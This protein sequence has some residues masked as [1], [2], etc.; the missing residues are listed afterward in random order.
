MA[1]TSPGK[2][3]GRS[4]RAPGISDL[5][6]SR[7]KSIAIEQSIEVRQLTILAGANSSG[8]SSMMQ[9]LLLLKQTLEAPYDPGP[10]ELRGPNTAF[11]N[12]RQLLSRVEGNRANGFDVGVTVGGAPLRLRFKY[13]PKEGLVLQEMVEGA[14]PARRLREGMTDAQIRVAAPGLAGLPAREGKGR[15]KGPR[16]EVIRDR[17]CLGILA[18]FGKS[19]AE[20]VRMVPGQSR[21]IRAVIHVPALR[22]NPR[23]RVYARTGVDRNVPGVFENYL[24]SIIGDWQE[25]GDARLGKVNTDLRALGLTSEVRA[26]MLSDTEIDLEVG[27]R[28]GRKRRRGDMISLADSGYGVSQ[29]L[30]VVVALHFADRGQMVYVEQPEIHLHP[31]AQVKLANVIARAARRGVRAVVETH[32]SLLLLALQTLVAQG[33]LDKDRVRL[34]WFRRD[35][36]GVTRVRTAELDESGSYGD[37]PEDFADAELGLQQRFLDATDGG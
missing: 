29:V 30:P 4:R 35:R 37:W 2:A 19:F 34:H 36:R 21:D 20:S 22:G 18:R 10:L 23:E 14:D 12:A 33:K 32:S 1:K 7:F 31:L 25:R 8:K 28:P 15:L 11:T 13:V 24:A 9:P 26:H 17:C 5:T 16:L 6:V 27:R 3:K